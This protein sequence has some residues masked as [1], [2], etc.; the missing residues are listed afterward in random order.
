MSCDRAFRVDL[1][2]VLLA[3]DAPGAAAF[4]AHYPTCRECAAE[5]RAWTELGL[6]LG[7]GGLH[8]AETRLL[9][10]EDDPGTLPAVERAAVAAHVAG[11]PACRDELAALRRFDPAALAAGA[12]ARASGP[13]RRFGWPALGR[14]VWHPAFAY[15]LVLLIAIPVVLERF[16]TRPVPRAEVGRQEAP[17]A[18]EEAAGTAPAQPTHAD[19]VGE[20][21]LAKRSAAEPRPAPPAAP[22]PGAA[23]S[24][25]VVPPGGSLALLAGGEPSA[26]LHLGR[27]PGAAA[28]PA[29]V[30]V[31]A[32]GGRRELHA[33]VTVPAAGPVEVD[34]PVAW[35]GGGTQRVELR[36]DG[37]VL[38]AYRIAVEPHAGR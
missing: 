37:A 28:G 12:P 34:L 24:I 18:L 31:I 17:R 38:S 9:G 21:A 14:L 8:P 15:A 23:V 22:A 30:V 19:A 1:T 29:E 25:P 6:L 7:G 10:F 13:R 26:R 16:A 5:V 2:E 33:R 20:A 35:L 36:R 4:R 11:C 32:P 3:G 27:P